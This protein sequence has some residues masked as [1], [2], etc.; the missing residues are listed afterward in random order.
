MM[1]TENEEGRCSDGCC[2]DDGRHMKIEWERGEKNII[3]NQR[4]KICG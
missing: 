1:M 2:G 3:L 4:F